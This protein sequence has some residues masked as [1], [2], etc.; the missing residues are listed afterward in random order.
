MNPFGFQNGRFLAEELDVAFLGAK[1]GTPFYCYST[2]ALEQNYRAFS[3]CFPQDVLIAYSVKANGNLAVLRTLSR[4]GAGADVVS[5]GELKKA[6]AAGIPANRI[7]FSGVGKS[8]EEL[9]LGLHAG[10]HQFNIE[11]EP[12]LECLSAV[13]ARAGADASVTIRVNPNIDARTH[14][15][16]ATGMAETKFGIPWSRVRHAYARAASLKGIKIVGVDVH[17]GSQLLELEP[18]ELAVARIAEL[19]AILRADG[20]EISRVDL[21]GGLGVRYEGGPSPDLKQYASLTMHLARDLNVSL[22]LEPGRVIAA[23]AGILVARVLYVKAGENRQF[24]II[25]AGMNDFIRPALYS[26]HHEIVCVCPRQ[27]A[28][29]EDYDVVGPVCETSDS[30]GRH[31]LPHLEAGDLVAVLMTGAYGAVMASAY[32][33]RP[34]APEVLVNA[35]QWSVVRPRMSDDEFIGLD[36][37]PGWL[38]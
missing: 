21:G 18:F 5:G 28:A 6:L 27:H 9:E 29:E 26:A 7:V 23:S 31:R 24:A 34:P 33:A 3:A 8:R 10:I 12:E 13:A 14:A 30:F 32:N 25:D 4:L 15:K 37:I 16:I 20:H 19:V 38:A 22:I 35:A 17:I 1:I 2:A 36:R 11:S